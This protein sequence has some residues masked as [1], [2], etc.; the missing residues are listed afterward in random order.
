MKISSARISS[1]TSDAV[2]D[3]SAGKD[4]DRFAKLLNAKRHEELDS[5]HH[6]EADV[7]WTM[8][9]PPPA[10]AGDAAAIQPAVDVQRLVDEIVQQISRENAGSTS[11]I[12]I[13]FQSAVLNGLRVQLQSQGAGVVVNFYTQSEEVGAALRGH[14]DEL[15]RMLKSKGFRPERLT[16]SLARPSSTPSSQRMTRSTA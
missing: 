16:V 10:E 9:A 6:S 13:Q 12:E 15:S 11:N 8:E 7:P 4:N 5:Q 1:N 2:H 14:F 3:D